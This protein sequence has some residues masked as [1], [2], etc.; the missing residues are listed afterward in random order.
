M[1]ISNELFTFFKFV[2]IGIV[3]SMIFDFFRAY[4]KT[5]KV[6]NFSVV[7]QDITYF[8]IATTIVTLGIIFFLES[9]IRLYVFIAIILG[10]LT[11]LSSFSK[12]IMSIYVHTINIFKY[13]FGF[14]LTPLKLMK[15]ILR[16]IHI[17]FKKY[18]KICCKKIKYMVS[19]LHSKIFGA[20]KKI[21]IKKKTKK[22][23]KEG[24]NY[25]KNT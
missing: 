20:V 5:K 18:V 25:E 19:Y 10:C 7:I 9:S 16:K 4:R 12:Y 11:Y 1:Y 22:C 17:F 24:Q 6:S 14:I 8:F 2:L 3:I 13:T 15:Q 21:K 23:T